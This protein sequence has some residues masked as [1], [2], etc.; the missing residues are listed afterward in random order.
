M[1][2]N[3]VLARVGRP[4]RRRL[5]AEEVRR[6]KSGD[7]GAWE[8]IELP[9]GTGSR[10]WGGDCRR[11]YRNKVFSVLERFLVIGVTHLAVAS[12]TEERPT[13]WEMQRIKCE[14]AGPD[15]TAVEVY[16][17]AAE[18]VDGADMFHIWVIPG[19]LSFSLWEI[20]ETGVGCAD[21]RRMDLDG[22]G[23]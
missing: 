11:A 12:L 7:W 1:I 10:G 23:G 15:A 14:L 16:P 22:A 3:D 20:T 17:P 2:G 5:L 9:H 13:W 8:V 4:E 19:G 18:V 6:R 21:G